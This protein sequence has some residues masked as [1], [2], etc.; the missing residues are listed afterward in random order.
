MPKVKMIKRKSKIK[1]GLRDLNTEQRNDAV[2]KKQRKGGQST[3]EKWF[4][5]WLKKGKA[6]GNK[7]NNNKYQNNPVAANDAT[8]GKKRQRNNNNNN[9]ANQPARRRT[10]KERYADTGNDSKNNSKASSTSSSTGAN[11]LNSSSTTA[12]AN[13]ERRSQNPL[14]G[15]KEDESLHDFQIRKAKETRSIIAKEEFQ[16]TKLSQKKKKYHERKKQK[17]K[18]KQLAKQERGYDSEED[19]WNAAAGASRTRAVAFGE[20]IDDAPRNLSKFKNKRFKNKKVVTLLEETGEMAGLRSS[21]NEPAREKIAKP[22]QNGETDQ[23]AALRAR[24]V[25]AYRSSKGHHVSGPGSKTDVGKGL[26]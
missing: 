1:Q 16:Q 17:I 20:R 26:Y 2:T 15:K 18:Q 22:R 9:N 6:S 8:I 21:W 24:V 12:A 11:S 23:M 5:S 7:K 10:S 13:A 19:E 14:A 25:D 4:S 3:K